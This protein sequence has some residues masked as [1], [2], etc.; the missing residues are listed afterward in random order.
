MFWNS[1]LARACV[2]STLIVSLIVGCQQGGE[3]ARSMPGALPGA[4]APVDRTPQIHAT[5]YF[6]HGHLLERQGAF[7]RAVEQYRRALELK[8]D[9]VIARNRL[10]ITLNKLGRHDEATEQFRAALAQK[11]DLAHLQNNLGFSLYLEHRYAESEIALA[12]ALELKPDFSRARMNHALSLAKLNRLD[13]AFAELSK[14]NT[15]ADAAYNMGMILTEAGRFVEAARSLEAALAAK[16]D[17]EAARA[18]LN[19]IARLAAEQDAVLRARAEA[20]ARAASDAIVRAEAQ[21]RVAAEAR[22]LADAQAAASIQPAT[23]IPDEQLM[24]ADE[25]T[26]APAEQPE[27]SASTPVDMEAD[28]CDEQR[29]S[30]ASFEAIEQLDVLEPLDLLSTALVDTIIDAVAMTGD[31]GTMEVQ[32]THESEPEL[33]EFEIDPNAAPT[34]SVT[35]PILNAGIV[36]ELLDAWVAATRRHADAAAEFFCR[37]ELYLITGSV[38]PTAFDAD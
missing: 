10:G 2:G 30:L 12:R 26:P 6:A 31:A 37:L 17:F 35:T 11:P 21:A 9:F 20:E 4:P 25:I 1:P 14:V 38:V 3:R 15:P 18:Q 16:P 19:E 33:V 28:P 5:T 13:E 22:A 8:S 34:L 24:T 32:R 7:D 29:G 36:E 27:A 23:L